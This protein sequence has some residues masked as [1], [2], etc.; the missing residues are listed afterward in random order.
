MEISQSLESEQL[1][2]FGPGGSCSNKSPESFQPQETLL[3]VSSLD[4]LAQMNRLCPAQKTASGE[5]RVLCL[6]P[7]MVWP[8]GC[9]MPNFSECP[10]DAKESSLLDILETGAVPRKYYLSQLACRGILRRAAKRGKSLPE[11]LRIMLEQ[12]ANPSPSKSDKENPGGGKGYLGSE[13]KAFTIAT[14][15]DQN[16]L[17]PDT[18]AYRWQNDKDGL[19][20]DDKSATIKGKG[21]STDERSVGAYIMSTGQARAEILEDRVPTLNCNHEAPICFTE[22]KIHSLRAEGF[23]RSEDGTGRGTPI[24]AFKQRP[25]GDIIQS[26]KAYGIPAAHGRNTAKILCGA[27]VRR[28]TPLEVERAQGFPDNHTQIP[29]KGNT[30]DQCPDG[31]RYKA[32]GNSWAVPCARW[33]GERILKVEAEIKS[34]Q[35]PKP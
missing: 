6:D 3:G 28:L 4:C 21:T 24:I 20:P 34:S 27:S 25:D 35:E 5:V 7:N 8:G 22:E 2:L 18:Q 10:N 13:D 15:T 19:V 9:L 14:G 32:I 33:I 1:N 12:I 30:A 17:I 29:Y 23:D 16:I 31:P 26:D 11:R